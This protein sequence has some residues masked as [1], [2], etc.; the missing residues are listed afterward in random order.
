MRDK[1][2]SENE[3]YSTLLYWYVSRFVE[4]LRKLP[5]DRWDWTFAPPAPTPRILA[6]HC[7]QCLVGDRQHILEPN[8]LLHPD[9]PEAPADTD[10]LCD[11]LQAEAE[12][13]RALVLGLTPQ[14]LDE[15]RRQFGGPE[16]NVRWFV[17]HMIQNCIYKH[18]QFA[19]IYFALGLDGT[20]PYDCPWP[21]RLYGRMRE[22]TLK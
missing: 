11:V 15:P 16:M 4:R 21:N 2:H 9:V 10:A 19:T 1:I 13:W 12:T 18:G 22:G 14:Q 8:A 6:T 3:A 17:C 5:A 20:E 7:W